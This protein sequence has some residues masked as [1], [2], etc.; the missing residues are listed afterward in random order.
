MDTEGGSDGISSSSYQQP[1][2]SLLERLRS[3][4]KAAANRKRKIALNLPH[5][6]M[7][8]TAPRCASDL[9]GITAAQR[10]AEYPNENFSASVKKLS[11]QLVEK[12]PPIICGNYLR[13]AI[14]YSRINRETEIVF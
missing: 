11:A 4:P 9:K 14:P 6:G 1:V 7:R 8:N 12:C 5:D 2:V 10:V 13:D 3:A